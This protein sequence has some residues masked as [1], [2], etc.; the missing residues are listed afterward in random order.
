[1]QVGGAA[2]WHVIAASAQNAL[3]SGLIPRLLPTCLC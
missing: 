1:M 2:A 3:H